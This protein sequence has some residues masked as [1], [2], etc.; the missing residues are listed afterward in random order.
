[1]RRALHEEHH[2]ILGDFLFDLIL[3]IGHSETS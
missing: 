1:L 2:G 3:D